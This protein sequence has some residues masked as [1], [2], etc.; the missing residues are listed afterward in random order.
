[1]GQYNPNTLYDLMLELKQ[2][3]PEIEPYWEDV[4]ARIKTYVHTEKHG[5]WFMLHLHFF[6]S[7]GGRWYKASKW[8]DRVMARFGWIRKAPVES[9]INSIEEHIKIKMITHS[10]AEWQNFHKNLEWV[11]QYGGSPQGYKYHQ[12]QQQEG[13][14]QQ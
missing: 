5:V 2:D 4:Y 7:K 12:Q 11:R 10:E 1:M 6:R 9:F 13:V 8:I 14:I 3:A